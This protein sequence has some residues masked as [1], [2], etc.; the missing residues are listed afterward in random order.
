MFFESH[1]CWVSSGT[2]R[3]RYCWLPREVSGEKPTIKKCRR[4]KGIR[5][6]ASLRRSEF[7]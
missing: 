6:T 5:F 2:D 4:G 7:S 3:E 1:I